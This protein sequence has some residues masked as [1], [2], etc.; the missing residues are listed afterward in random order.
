MVEA[1]LLTS[2]ARIQTKMKTL[3]HSLWQCA[4]LILLLTQ[5]THFTEPIGQ[6]V[7]L[8]RTSMFLCH[9]VVNIRQGRAYNHVNR[10]RVTTIQE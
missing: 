1:Q 9:V 6:M 7:I 10:P 2:L 4:H 8:K 5:T 3:E